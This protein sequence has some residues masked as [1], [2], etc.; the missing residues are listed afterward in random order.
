MPAFLADPKAIF[1][2]VGAFFYIIAYIPYLREMRAGKT[3]PHTYTWL[4]WAITT[5]TAAAGS[6]YGGG[7]WSAANQA[8]SFLLTSLFLI[9]SVRYGTKDITRSDTA[10]LLLALAAIVVWWQ[11]HSPVL[12]V[13]M[14][15][16]IDGAAY[17]P[18]V[19]K[20][21]KEPQ[22]ESL[23]TWSLFLLYSLFAFLAIGEYNLLTVPYL[24]MTIAANALVLGIRV[25]RP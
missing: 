8:L 24:L 20:L 18:T 22:S 16:A 5:G 9:L 21:L 15:T 17:V 14:V 11:L 6:W 13:L 7:G 19:R 25:R 3:K 1:S 23:Y 4:I 12:A 2:I 10:I